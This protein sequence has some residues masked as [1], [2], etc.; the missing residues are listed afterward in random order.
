MCEICSSRGGYLILSVHVNAIIFNIFLKK[1]KLILFCFKVLLSTYNPDV[2]KDNND[3][4]RYLTGLSWSIFQIVKDAIIP[5]MHNPRKNLPQ[6]NQ[7]L[8]VLVRLRLN[9]PFEYLSMQTGISQSTIHS[10]FQKIIDIMYRKL[11][12]LIHWPDREFIRQTLPPVFRAQFP[13]LT[14]I[15]DCFEIFIERPA[16]LKARAQVYS[17][18]KKHSTIK[19]FICCSPL[20]AITFL[21]PAWG[22]RATD[23]HIVRQSGFIHTMNTMNLVTKYWQIEGLL[24]LMTLQLPVKQSL[25]FL[26]SHKGKS[27]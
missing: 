19:F 24:W 4:S 25:L 18:Y 23:N 9:L 5:F 14:S 26:A 8:M 15:V 17:N 10:W 1:S 20:G 11:K 6:Q 16:N 22:G 27:N 3:A 21:S 7:I 12:F 13:R 2:M